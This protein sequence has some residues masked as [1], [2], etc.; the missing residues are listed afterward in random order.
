D[1]D[2]AAMDD[3][4]DDADDA[5]P[6]KQ[7]K[8][9]GYALVFDVVRRFAQPLGIDLARW[10]GRIIATEKGVVRLLPVRD[11]ARQLFGRDGAAAIAQQIVR[12]PA[13]SMQLSLFPDPAPESHPP[14]AQPADAR[15]QR[16]VEPVETPAERAAT[17]LDRVHLAML[18]QASGQ[19]EA[20]RALLR[21]EQE[22]GPD[23]LRLANALSALYPPGS[24]EKRLLDAM[25]LAVPR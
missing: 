23:F 13:Q 2:A 5:R 21:A 8:D 18:F 19:A 3:E 6:A 15:R 17:T 10:E 12:A 7:K 24:E 14:R 20:L 1:D 16:R 9:G 22:R 4:G 25:L 11:R